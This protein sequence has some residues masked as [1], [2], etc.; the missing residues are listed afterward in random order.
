MNLLRNY[1]E[2]LQNLRVRAGLTVTDLKNLLKIVLRDITIVLL[3]TATI[4][5]YSLYVGIIE[6]GTAMMLLSISS[7]IAL[8]TPHLKY[9]F[10]IRSRNKVLEREFIYFIISESITYSRSTELV[11]DLCVLDGWEGVFPILVNEGLRLRIYRKFLT[12]IEAINFYIRYTSS[13]LISRLLSDYIL[14]YSKGI[15]NAWF[16][17]TSSELLR[18]L[19]SE[20][21]ALM[22]LRTT[23]VLIMGVVVSYL[24]MLMFSLSIIT[25]GGELNTVLVVVPVLMILSMF[26]LPSNTQHLRMYNKSTL[27]GKL[28]TTSSYVLISL[29]AISTYLSLGNTNY[30]IKA[31]A[32]VSLFNG[33]LNIVELYNTVCE[34]HELPKVLYMYAE[35]PHILVNPLNALKD[36][37]SSC[38][39]KSLRELGKK[40]SLSNV[41]EGVSI[42][43]SWL[44]R[45]VYYVIIKSLTTGSLGK[46]Q[47]LNLRV[48][49]LDML[50]DFKQYLVSVLPLIMMSLLMPFFMVSMASLANVNI[51]N[52]VFYIYVIVVTYSLYV[53]YTLFNTFNSTLIT[54]ITLL[55]LSISW[56]Y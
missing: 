51:S 13:S 37:L 3:P 26:I 33:V 5:T 48:L 18:R 36:V 34:V 9:V 41:R 16:T 45:Y 43:K 27:V 7:F 6:L 52:Y 54:G 24:P 49:T 22:K 29:T 1:L 14:A 53:D 20:V 12:T 15:I 42:L 10:V 4:T 11:N 50:E 55:I 46:E 38:K 19:R 40:L 30:L 47:L 28:V 31:A 17:H 2:S 39:S 32:T 35:T 25:G 8:I 21:T 44:G 23:V 56:C